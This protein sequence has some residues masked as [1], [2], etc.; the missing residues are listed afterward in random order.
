MQV[1]NL[2]SKEHVHIFTAKVSLCV[3][4]VS[5]SSLQFQNLV[6]EGETSLP[7]VTKSCFFKA[8]GSDLVPGLCTYIVSIREET[9]LGYHCNDS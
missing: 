5:Q 3:N 8:T 2:H 1:A 4:I 9:Q 6:L 7:E